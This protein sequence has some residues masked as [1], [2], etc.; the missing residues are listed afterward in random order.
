MDINQVH[1]IFISHLLKT[2]VSCD[3]RLIVNKIVVGINININI[4]I[5][6]VL[7]ATFF[8]DKCE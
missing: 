5:N 6:M 8:F 2:Q 1:L 3:A 4:N 7:K